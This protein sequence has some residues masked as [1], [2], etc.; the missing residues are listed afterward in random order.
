M[1]S[2]LSAAVVAPYRAHHYNFLA[3][4][5]HDGIVSN[6]MLAVLCSSSHRAGEAFEDI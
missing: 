6:I 4:V 1:K 5:E 2:T 3:S